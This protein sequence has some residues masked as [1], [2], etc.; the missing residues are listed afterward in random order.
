M[1]NACMAAATRDDC[2]NVVMGDVQEDKTCVAG[3]C[4]PVMGNKKIT[5]WEFCPESTSCPGTPLSTLGDLTDCI[6]VAADAI[7][8]ELLCLQFR[9]N[10]GA[11]W[12]CPAD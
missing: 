4:D 5:W 6:D 8:D 1:A 7:S 3:Q 2:E 9:G 12:P 10:N 11:D